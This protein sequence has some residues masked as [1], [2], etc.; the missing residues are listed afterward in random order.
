VSTLNDL[1]GEIASS[2]HSYTGVQEQSTH[3]TTAVNTTDLSFAVDSSDGIS[4][5]IAEVDDEMVYVTVVDNNTLTIPP[6]GRGYRGSTAATHA[7]NTQ[8]VCDPAFPRS[9]IRKAVEQCMLGLYP[10]LFQIKTVDLA[11]SVLPI[12][13]T[14]PADCDQVLDV[15]VQA[16]SDPADYW[17]PLYNWSF[18]S[19]SAESSTKALNLF[20]G[21]AAGSTIHVVYQAG[22]GTFAALTDTLASVGLKESYADMIM[23]NVTARMLRF[24]ESARVQ[25]RTVENLS[26]SAVVQVGDATKVANQ[27]YAMYQQRLQEERSKLLALTP[28]RIHFQR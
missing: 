8:V 5:G 26:R 22:F 3:L 1:I 19:T 24:A 17:I 6:Y 10:T 14:L 13:Y 20:D 7:L 25:T 27:L 21:C 12:G 2:L 18:D 11:Y 28:A 9:E 15:K 23:Y 16:P 4:R